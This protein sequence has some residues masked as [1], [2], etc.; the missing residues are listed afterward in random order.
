M[1]ESLRCLL[2]LFAAAILEIG[3]PRVASADPVTITSGSISIPASRT[4]PSPIQIEG[5]DGVLTFSLSGVIGAASSMEL[6]FCAPCLPTATTISLA[7]NSAGLDIPGMLTYGVDSYRVGGLEDTFGTVVLELSGFAVL[8]RAP[9]VINELATVTGPFELLANSHFSPPCCGGP[10]NDLRGSGTATVLLFGDP[11]GGVPVWAFRSAEY[12]F[13][14]QAPI[15]EPASFVLL[16]S[17]LIGV[18]VRRR[19]GR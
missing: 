10:G 1:K 16:A 11:G 3:V 13:T 5:T 14:D 19:R 15:P 17:G 18:A 2:V 8:P 7:I 4:R 12:R 9:S 6:F